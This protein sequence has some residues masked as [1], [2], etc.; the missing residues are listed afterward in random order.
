MRA[1]NTRPLLLAALLVSV[2]LTVAHAQ[3]PT[4]A[5]ATALLQSRPDLV[6]QLRRRIISSGM[7]PDQIRARLKAEGYPENLLDPYLTTESLTGA[8]ADS[9]AST[10]V[11]AAVGALG[12][13]DTSDVGQL[14]REVQRPAK[15]GA[16]PVP[17]NC[18]SL[19]VEADSVVRVD[20]DPRCTTAETPRSP[21]PRDGSAL[22]G[23]EVF[24]RRTSQFEAN[25]AGPVD[26]SYRLGPGDQLVLILTGD[27]ELAHQLTV[28]REG[29]VVIPQV[30]QLF[31]A[32]VT[33][34][35]LEDLLYSRLGRVYS[36]VRRGPGATTR[37]SVSVSKL[38]SN[39]VYVVGEVV[40]PGAYRVS[41]AGTALTALYAAAGP[42]ENG[43]L[44][45][46]EVRRGD[47]VVSALDVY[48]YLLRGDASR[49]VRLE[50]GDVIFVPV[51]G[52]RVRVVGE[53]VRPATYELKRGEQLEDVLRAAGGLTEIAA[54]R[55]VQVER[56]VPPSQRAASGHERVVIDIN[57]ES[58]MDGSTP[59]FGMQP[60]DVVRVFPISER[61]RN[62]VTVLGNV[63]LPGAQGYKPGMK[64]SDALRAA[65]GL[66]PNVYLGQVLVTRMRPDSTP[67][68]LRA[69]LRDT[70]GVVVGDIPLQEDDAIRVFSTTEFRPTR[71][72]AISGAVRKS[73]RYP[74]REGMTIRD[75]VLLAGG[76]EE[77]AFLGE[78]EIARL[79]ED[80][81]G[82]VLARTIRTPLDSSYVFGRALDGQ[83]LTSLEL[84][85]STGTAGEPQ[86]EPYDNVLIL[87]QPNWS[88]QRT[89]FLGGEVR[90]PGRY[91]LLNKN[92]KLT[93]L[94]ARAG[95]LT[96]E[97][98]AD[99]VFFF[100]SQNGLGRVGIDLP[101]ALKK[102]HSRDNLL[103]LDGDSITIPAY[104]AIVN[105]RGA[106]NSPVAV[107]YV[108]GKDI[109]FYISAAGGPG[110]AADTRRAYVTQP[111]GKVESK[112]RG[113]FTQ[114]RPRAGS[115]VFVP[116]KDTTSQLS[117]L[118]NLSTSLQ[119][120]TA[121]VSLVVLVKR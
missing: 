70:T 24:Q 85:L 81:S 83:Y 3:R 74:Y 62:R 77:S 54:Q 49:D 109:D 95:G 71:Y 75:L 5:E 40:N 104:S 108:P 73:G 106:V 45:R 12:I 67:I 59:P 43:S 6:E 112:R 26:P 102:K 84:P 78:A 114:P 79:P 82:G 36:G 113:S 11:L 4:A 39:Q 35:Q 65:G 86:L 111:S 63:W 69:R 97:A 38:R 91:A 25:L 27:V 34:G 46:V 66:K 41:S 115:T 42:T 80:R 105:V 89:V 22:F 88:L 30:G 16:V 117:L 13:I 116:T 17:I 1:V 50:T 15:L 9:V 110:R 99:G 100:R 51:H 47:K 118:A 21:F 58:F 2:P 96:S 76:L 32:N 60:G 87:R 56:I 68:Q 52:A 53:V 55:R 93:D 31:V 121:L 103:L 98:Y 10:D 64:L 8:G 72:V 7:S 101:G 119:L 94:I 14:R 37:F 19:R 29:F 18:D 48:D 23:L 92:E 44:R 61:V 57:G 28:S 20:I 33:L 120:L 90:F 107:A